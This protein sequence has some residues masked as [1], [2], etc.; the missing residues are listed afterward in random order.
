MQKLLDDALTDAVFVEC[1]GVLA[2]VL[3]VDRFCD[4]LGRPRHPLPAPRPGAPARRRPAPAKAGLARVPLVAPE[5]V[6]ETCAGLYAGLSGAHI[7]RAL[8]L[9]PAEVRGFFD[10]DAEMYL[11]DAKLRDFDD[12]PRALT[13]A[14]LE[15]LAARVSALNRCYY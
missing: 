7:H 10:L 2:T 14:Q 13:H 8:S 6:D 3:A 12:E 1:V 4:A 9:V 5:D 15:L 11:P